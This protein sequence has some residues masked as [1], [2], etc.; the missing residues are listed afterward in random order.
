MFKSIVQSYLKTVTSE[1][2]EDGNEKMKLNLGD[3]FGKTDL[4]LTNLTLRPDAFDIGL[5]PL[6]LISGHISNLYVQG[7]AEA[8]MGGTI[9]IVIEECYLL[10]T[11][12][13]NTSIEQIQLMKKLLLEMKYEAGAQSLWRELIQSIQGVALDAIDVLKQK[14]QSLKVKHRFYVL[15]IEYFA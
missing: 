6:R 14:T 13:T 11:I 7:V 12:D 5:H 2:F 8:F 1:L 4:T 9:Q 10:F 3:L 15:S